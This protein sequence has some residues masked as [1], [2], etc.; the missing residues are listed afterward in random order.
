MAPIKIIFF[1]LVISFKVYT[2]LNKFARI[3]TTMVNTIKCKYCGK[4]IEISEAL[5]HEVQAKIRQELEVEIEEKVG[6]RVN[7]EYELT[8]KQQ[9]KEIAE[10]NL[11]NR[12]LLIQIEELMD[13]MR[14]LKTKD[15]EREVEMRK[16]LAE[17]QEKIKQAAVGEAEERHK[18]DDREKD[19]KLS[20]ALAQIEELKIKIQQKSGQLQGEVLE[21]DLENNLKVA[22]PEDE[23]TPVGKGVAGGDIVQKVKNRAGKIAGTIIWETKR[24]KWSR[25]WLPKLRGDTRSA[26][27]TLAVLVSENLPAD[28]DTFSVVDGILVTSYKY[29]LSLASLLRRSVMQIA[30]AKFLASTKVEDLQILHEYLQSDAFRHR[31]EAFFEGVKA[32]EEDLMGEKRSMERIWKKREV[33]IRKLGGSASNMYGEL[34]GIMGKSLPDIKSL[35]LDSG[36]NEND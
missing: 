31:F 9:Q 27:A 5:T 26:G 10:T 15:E 12:K 14:L 22:F 29:A 30:S 13:Q 19:K 4:D 24:A 25:S 23:I 7:E 6:K 20:D 8:Q 16:R 17:A 28:I 11:R 21:L 34:Q 35:S 1:F 2:S 18:L 32:M 3:L 33:Q 36:D